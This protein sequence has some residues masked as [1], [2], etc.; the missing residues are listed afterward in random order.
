MA[1]R[2]IQSAMRQTVSDLELIVVD[3][4][5]V[6]STPELLRTFNDPRLV[7]IRNETPRGAN[8]A[9]NQG[10]R[11]ARGAF[12]AF[13]DDDDSW[14]PH[15]LERQ[16]AAI[17]DAEAIVCGAVS[18]GGRRFPLHHSAVVTPE[19][20]RRGCRLWGGMSAI[21]LRRASAEQLPL[22]EELPSGQD[23]DLLIRLAARQNIRYLPDWLVE[24]NDG[25]HDRITNQVSD[26]TRG[27]S[28]ARLK[29][30]TKHRDF[31]GPYWTAFHS[32]NVQLRCL[33][34][35]R[36]RL[37]LLASAADEFG[38]R[39]VARVLARRAWYRLRRSAN[40]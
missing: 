25:Q 28:C 38:F 23:W 18:S 17:G 40:H 19:D 26:T 36:Q 3:D 6:D 29:S 10:V 27:D 37:A 12:V 20:L 11:V 24:Y 9:R 33:S 31:L 16:L 34:R 7:A 22:D 1:Q 2:A 30:V 13:L 39:I 32:A 4:G 21:L 8:A 15:K 14:L 35:R 5:S